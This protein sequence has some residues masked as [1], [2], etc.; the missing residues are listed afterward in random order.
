V[1]PTR[2][3]ANELPLEHGQKL[4]D[5]DGSLHGR[6]ELTNAAS[7][8]HFDMETAVFLAGGPRLHIHDA[9]E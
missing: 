2:G 4:L 1:C 9:S 5:R 6:A 7:A 3:N 8:R